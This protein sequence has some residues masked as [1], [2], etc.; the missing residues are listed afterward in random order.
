MYLSPG[1]AAAPAGRPEFNFENLN[2][3]SLTGPIPYS[4]SGKVEGAWMGP[5]SPGVPDRDSGCHSTRGE[6]KLNL[7][8]ESCT[9]LG[10]L[11]DSESRRS[12]PRP[13]SLP[14]AAARVKRGHWA[15]CRCRCPGSVTVD[16]PRCSLEHWQAENE[17]GPR[18]GPDSE[19]PDSERPKAGTAATS[20]STPGTP[21][22]VAPDSESRGPGPASGA[23][24][25]PPRPW[26]TRTPICSRSGGL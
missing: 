10:P 26:R 1:R 8:G 4:L 9:S 18:R 12:E 14:L 17:P 15:A 11:S 2:A 23:H 13:S 20:A 25:P 22:D 3:Q 21:S 24:A 6:V 19:V 7:N 16:P 5:P